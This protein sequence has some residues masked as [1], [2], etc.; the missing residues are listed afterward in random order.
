MNAKTFCPAAASPACASGA[1]DVTGAAGTPGLMLGAALPAARSV[2]PAPAGNWKLAGGSALTLRP[3]Q[4]MLLRAVH[5]GLWVTWQVPAAWWARGQTTAPGDQFL[6]AGDT[7]MLPAGA[8]VVLEPWNPGAL[9]THAAW[10]GFDCEVQPQALPLARAAATTSL[11]QPL[12]DLRA[13]F[14][15]MAAA[16]LRLALVLVRSAVRFATDFVAA[17]A[18]GFGRERGLGV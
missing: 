14:G 17:C 4:P 11:R 6:A 9:H 13:G 5:G 2:C 10:S 16:L 1:S 12:A 3:R 8:H 18:R 15:L 7:C